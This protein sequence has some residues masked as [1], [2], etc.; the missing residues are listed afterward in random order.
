MTRL[1]KKGQRFFVLDYE[2][3]GVDTVKDHP[4]EVGIIACDENFAVLDTRQ[5]FIEPSETTIVR[6]AR[7]TTWHES[8]LGSFRVHGIDPGDAIR[9]GADVAVGEAIAGFTLTHTIWGQKPV[10]VSDNIQFEWAFTKR[11][12]DA[13][14]VAWP[15][16]YCGWDTSLFLEATGVGDPYPVPHRA[17]ADAGLLHAAIVKALDRTRSLR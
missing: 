1:G 4:I 11:L 17:L 10:L 16:H 8:V 7:G 13:A 14:K 12:I 9:G 3:T 2:T 15:F 6:G 5:W